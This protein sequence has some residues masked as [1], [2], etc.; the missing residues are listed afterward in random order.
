M[1]WIRRPEPPAPHERMPLPVPHAP[2]ERELFQLL[3]VKTQ[4]IAQEGDFAGYLNLTRELLTACR[5]RLGPVHP[6]TQGLGL[7][8]FAAFA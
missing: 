3:W 7:T 8:V 1:T 5:Y 4:A 2:E 6:L